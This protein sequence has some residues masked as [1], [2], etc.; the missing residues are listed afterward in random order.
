[1]IYYYVNIVDVPN[2]YITLLNLLVVTQVSLIILKVIQ[3]LI[4]I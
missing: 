2:T 4:L 1:M 3:S